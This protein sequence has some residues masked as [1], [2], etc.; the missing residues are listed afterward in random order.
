[1]RTMAKE[2]EVLLVDNR[3]LKK[4]KYEQQ[5]EL[6]R[7]TQMRGQLEQDMDRLQSQLETAQVKERN[8]DQMRT[9][10]LLNMK[11]EAQQQSQVNRSQ[12]KELNQT[13]SQL[14]KEQKTNNE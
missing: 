2:Q 3:K 4:E 9:Q 8:S 10:Q 7:E 14:H 1:M 6:E 13:V 12:L 5:S 11:T